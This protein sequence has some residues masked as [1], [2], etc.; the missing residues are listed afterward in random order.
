MDF[1]LERSCNLAPESD[2]AEYLLE[3]APLSI[4]GVLSS[5]KIPVIGVAGSANS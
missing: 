4:G 3:I 1:A 2:S 5:P